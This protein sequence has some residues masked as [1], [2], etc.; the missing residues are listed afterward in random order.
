MGRAGEAV[1]KDAGLGGLVSSMAG[2]QGGPGRQGVAGKQTVGK[3]HWADRDG[4]TEGKG[5]PGGWQTV[6]GRAKRG[7]LPY[8]CRG[9][10]CYGQQQGRQGL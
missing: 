2:A 5:E 3:G 8:A 10:A 9:C 4:W 6:V 1:A 7:L